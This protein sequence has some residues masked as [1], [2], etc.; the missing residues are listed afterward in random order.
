MADLWYSGPK[1]DL[2]VEYKF[3]RD[4]KIP[5]RAAIDPAKYLSAMQLDWL[6]TQSGYGRNVWVIIGCKDGGV[7][8]TD[9]LSWTNPWLPE[10]FRANL[11]DRK[12]LA[13]TIMA[14]VLHGP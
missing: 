1:G 8:M 10:V 12:S 7:I 3:L 9:P 4:G 11:Q 14:E 5:I 13:T 2:W 6:N